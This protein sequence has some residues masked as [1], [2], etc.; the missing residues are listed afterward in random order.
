MSPYPHNDIAELERMLSNYKRFKQQLHDP[1]TPHH[2]QQIL[3]VA[4]T[5]L[6]TLMSNKLRD[7]RR[8]LREL[9]EY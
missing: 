7:V 2:E 8:R 9:G 3:R 6:K 1:A 5:E 4:L